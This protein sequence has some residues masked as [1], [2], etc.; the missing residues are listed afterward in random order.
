MNGSSFGGAYPG[1][2]VLQTFLEGSPDTGFVYTFDGPIRGKVRVTCELRPGVF[3]VPVLLLR[4]F[5]AYAL[6]RY[7]YRAH[8]RSEP[9]LSRFAGSLRARGT[10]GCRV[11]AVW[12]GETATIGEAAPTC[13]MRMRS[14]R[15]PGARLRALSG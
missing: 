4:C 11:S 14:R 1:E 7:H 3:A 13:S 8:T 6:T 15:R 2:L 12:C 5:M 10:S 9:L